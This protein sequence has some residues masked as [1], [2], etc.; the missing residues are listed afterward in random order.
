MKRAS[1]SFLLL[2]LIFFSCDL[3][4]VDIEKIKI[5]TEEQKITILGVSFTGEMSTYNDIA[6]L[7]AYKVDIEDNRYK[8]YIYF[9]KKTSDN[10]EYSGRLY[11]PNLASNG[12]NVGIYDSLLIVAADNSTNIFEIEDSNWFFKKLLTSTKSEVDIYKHDVVMAYFG[13]VDFFNYDG[14]NW[15]S[16]SFNSSST[17]FPKVKL[18]E[19]MALIGDYIFNEYRGAI[20]IFKKSDIW[21]LKNT[22]SA[23]DAKAGDNFAYDIDVSE[24]YIIAGAPSYYSNDSLKTTSAYIFKLRNDEWVLDEKLFMESENQNFDFGSSVAITNSFAVIGAPCD[25]EG[26]ERAGAAYLYK[27]SLSGWILKAKLMASDA[28]AWDGFGR[29]ILITENNDILIAASRVGSM[30]YFRP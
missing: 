21:E 1:I 28:E 23:W 15:V 30:Y 12:A 2:V 10:W 26:G 9:L 5:K 25:N 24:D 8:E 6:A 29:N 20:K 4:K 18:R 16:T 27:K 7:S 19:N 3:F 17:D 14:Y 22:L 11:V 13:H